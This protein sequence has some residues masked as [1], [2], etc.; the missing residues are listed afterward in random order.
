MINLYRFLICLVSNSL[1]FFRYRRDDC[2]TN[3]HWVILSNSFVRILIHGRET[4]KEVFATWFRRYHVKR[5]HGL[6]ITITVK[7]LPDCTNG[8]KASKPFTFWLTRSHSRNFFRGSLLRKWDTFNTL[9][10]M[11]F[12]YCV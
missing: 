3:T 8:F 1:N 5:H 2:S 6:A 10:E 12:H 11:R 7:N 9:L 4:R